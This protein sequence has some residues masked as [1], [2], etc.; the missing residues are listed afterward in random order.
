M[1]TYIDTFNEALKLESDELL[2]VTFYNNKTGLRGKVTLS[3]DIQYLKKRH[4]NKLKTQLR[5]YEKH[6][7]S[8]CSNVTIRRLRLKAY[9]NTD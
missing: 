7:I 4:L 5:N 1:K 8:N 9:N 6:F 2:T 3:N